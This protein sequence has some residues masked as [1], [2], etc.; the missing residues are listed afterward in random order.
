[1]D[2][3]FPPRDRAEE[4][5]KATVKKLEQALISA[6]NLKDYLIAQQKYEYAAKARDVE[7]FIEQSL[8]FIKSID[9][10]KKIN[11]E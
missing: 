5:K 1:M 7:K 9:V 8:E 6:V 10:I 4:N 2:I 3:Q 11:E